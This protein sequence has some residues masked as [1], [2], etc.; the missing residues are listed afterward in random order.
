MSTTWNNGVFEVAH[1]SGVG[2]CVR[3]IESDVDKRNGARRSKQGRRGKRVGCDGERG[4]EVRM[5]KM[6]KRVRTVS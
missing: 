6:K 5:K 3:A 2:R 4:Q 1:A